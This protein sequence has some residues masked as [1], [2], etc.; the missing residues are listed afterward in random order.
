MKLGPRINYC[1]LYERAACAGREKTIS[2][3][4]KDFTL[5]E[6]LSLSCHV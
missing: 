4:D 2:E 5:K 6:V 3:E 1:K